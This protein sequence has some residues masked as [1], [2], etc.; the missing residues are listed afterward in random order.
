[1]TRPSDPR[2]EAEQFLGD[3]TIRA[4]QAD[5]R[6]LDTHGALVD[7]HQ[8]GQYVFVVRLVRLATLAAVLS[9]CSGGSDATSRSGST[10]RP[11]STSST[12]STSGREADEG[13]ALCRAVKRQGELRAADVTD[14]DATAALVDALPSDKKLD[15]ALFYY[16]YGGDIPGGTDTSGVAAQAAGDRLYELYREECGYDGP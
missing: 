2:P 15:A 11:S 6:Y 1:V 8:N 10:S 14:P 3:V 4:E 16:P 7:P 13:S 5:D 9:A 12:S